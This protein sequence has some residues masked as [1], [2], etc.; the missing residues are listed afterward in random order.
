MRIRGVTLLTGGVLVVVGLLLAY[1]LLSA[2]SV[3]TQALPS[4]NSEYVIAYQAPLDLLFP[5]ML[6]TVAWVSDE[7]GANLSVYDCG[8]DAGCS[9][10]GTVPVAYGYGL[11]GNLS[12]FGWANRYYE[13]RP[14]GGAM[15]VT[16]GYT[17]PILGGGL[18]LAI[19]LAGLI[20]VVVGFTVPGGRRRSADE[21]AV[22]PAA[23]PD[24]RR[25]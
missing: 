23:G 24:P 13:I 7:L 17:T 16:V 3:P 8:G 9:H 5:R 11:R 4:S 18:G 1:N 10:P 12:F 19:V 6:F 22:E 21:E 14:A 15:N 25:R 2:Q 20:L